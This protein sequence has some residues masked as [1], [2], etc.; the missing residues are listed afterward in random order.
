LQTGTLAGFGSRDLVG[1]SLR[2]TD[3][4]RRRGAATAQAAVDDVG[5]VLVPVR[6]D[7]NVVVQADRTVDVVADEAEPETVVPLDDRAAVD[8][9][10]FDRVPGDAER[11]PER[12]RA[13]LDVHASVDGDEVDLNGG[14]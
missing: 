11:T 8:L 6:V 12:P 9:V 14:R 4:R 5:H 13:A 2:V 7:Q 3:L 10:V 1:A